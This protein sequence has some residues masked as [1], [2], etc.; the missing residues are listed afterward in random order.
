MKKLI[1][2]FLPFVFLFSVTICFAQNYYLQKCEGDKQ[3]G[4][5]G[6]ELKNDFVVRLFD[7]QNNP[8]SNEEIV[9]YVA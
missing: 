4:L 1:K 6:I 5:R 8:V 9:F 2:L 7:S 3:L